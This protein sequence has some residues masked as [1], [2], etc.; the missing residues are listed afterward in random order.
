MSLPYTSYKNF[1]INR[2]GDALYRIPIDFNFGCPNREKDGSGGCTFCNIRGSAAVQTLGSENVK[3]QMQNAINFSKKRY[4]AKKFMAYVQAFSATFGDYQQPLYLNLINSFPFAAVSIGTR[5]DCIT[6]QALNFL[7]ILNQKIEVWVELGVQTIHDKTLERINRGH[8]WKS[9]LD[10]IKKLNSINIPVALHAII[11]LPGESEDDYMATAETFSNLPIQAV[12]IHNLHI[13]R[14][15]TLALENLINPVKVLNEYEFGDHLINFIRR[16]P[17]NLPIM[18]FTTDTPSNELIAPRWNMD[19][20]QFKKYIINQMEN[21]EQRQGDMYSKKNIKYTKEINLITKKTDDS[22]ITFWNPYYKECY[23]SSLGGRLE[24]LEKYVYPSE[25]SKIIKNKNIRILDIC[26]GLG[27][28]SF[29]SINK[30]IENKNI[31]EITALEIDKR[32]IR[33]ASEKIINHDEDAF[34]WKKVLGTLYK[35]YSSNPTDNSKIELIIG[36]AR[37]TIQKLINFS[38]D[39]AYLDAFSSTKNSE[40]WSIEFLKLINGKLNNNGKLLTYSSSG[41]VRASMILAGFYIGKTFS[42]NNKEGTIA[43]KNIQLLKNPINKNEINDL[44]SSTKGIPFRDP[45]LTNSNKEI[46]RRREKE[47]IKFKFEKIN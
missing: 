20:Q 17:E 21:R 36:D 45:S 47:L 4:K 5:P 41:P 23:H 19:K 25:I 16:L 30:T 9:S 40:L 3:E 46:L 15:T 14:G 22:S 38:Y 39:I 18:R 8:D 43:T 31:I 6:P 29:S 42:S 34:N 2:H 26:F 37:H 12:K 1:M 35:K 32:I 33:H 13:E 10:A 24:S 28:N 44:L 27:Y 7:K 11:G